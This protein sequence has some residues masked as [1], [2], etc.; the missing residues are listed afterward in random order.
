[1]SSSPGRSGRASMGARRTLAAGAVLGLLGVMA[2]AFGAHALR[3]AVSERDLEIW[4]TGAHYQQLHA[5]VLVAVA[6]MARSGHRRALAVASLLLTAGVLVFSGTLYAM[7][8]GGPRVLGAITPL[9]GLCLMGGWAALLVHAL[10]MARGD[11]V[12]PTSG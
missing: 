4:Q 8:L 10:T 5:V 6:V 9:G 1:M 3:G 11:D 2:G 7:V 12:P